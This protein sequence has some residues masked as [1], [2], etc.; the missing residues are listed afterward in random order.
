LKHITRRDILKSAGAL[1]VGLAGA[2]HVFPEPY[3][4]QAANLHRKVKITDVKCIIVRGTWDWNLIRIETEAGPY[5]D[6]TGNW[7]KGS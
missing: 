7:A 6:A 3:A 4:S 1:G 5:C 2:R